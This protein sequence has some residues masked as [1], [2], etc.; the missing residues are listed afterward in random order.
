MEPPTPARPGRYA[1]TRRLRVVLLG[2]SGLGGD[3]GDN[4]S[5]RATEGPRAMRMSVHR[6][7]V[8]S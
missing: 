7:H 5:Y 4:D 2:G 1:P 8:L 3:P 6:V